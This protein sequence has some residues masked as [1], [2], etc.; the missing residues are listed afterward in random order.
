MQNRRPNFR[1]RFYKLASELALTKGASNQ[2]ENHGD[3][4]QCADDV[5]HGCGP[6][7]L[8]FGLLLGYTFTAGLVSSSSTE[9]KVVI[10]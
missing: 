3:H 1:R 6:V 7:D 10:S 8:L 5:P 9:N 4:N 2:R